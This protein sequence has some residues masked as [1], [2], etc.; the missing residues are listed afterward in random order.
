MEVDKGD[1]EKRNSSSEK[2]KPDKMSK[3]KGKNG[4]SKK[5]FS[6]KRMAGRKYFDKETKN[7]EKE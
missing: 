2:K 3:N 1:H 6:Q 5:K 4:E 7:I